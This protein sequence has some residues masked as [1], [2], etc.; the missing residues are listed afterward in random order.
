MVCVRAVSCHLSC[1]AVYVND[2]IN[3]LELSKLGCCIGNL[4]ICCPF[5]ADD[6]VLLSGSVS[7][8]Q[9]MLNIV[10]QLLA[11]PRRLR[12]LTQRWMYVKKSETPHGTLLIKLYKF[13]FVTALDQHIV[14]QIQQI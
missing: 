5:Y 9:M 8:L 2:I 6:I 7:K 13:I 14:Q 12:E 4:N 1:F 3:K 11:E 10:T